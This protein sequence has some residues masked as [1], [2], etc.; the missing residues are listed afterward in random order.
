MTRS[1]PNN[2][3]RQQRDAAVERDNHRCRNCGV[4]EGMRGITL[5][6]HHIVPREVGGTHELRNLIT[7]CHQCH[8]AVHYGD[9]TAPQDHLSY[10]DRLRESVES[11]RWRQ[12]KLTDVS[13]T[14]IA[15]KVGGS[16]P[17]PTFVQRHMDVRSTIP[18]IRPRT[19]ADF[20]GDVRTHNDTDSDVCVTE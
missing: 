6:V 20:I 19:F 3:S 15:R 2:W 7:L 1:L 5:E 4:A 9:E 16:F 18:D 8:N 10:F 13:P 14:S 11:F 17:K 12:A